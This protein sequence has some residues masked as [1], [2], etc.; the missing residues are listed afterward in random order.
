[1]FNV[2]MYWKNRTEIYFFISTSEINKLKADVV[3]DDF[4]T[5]D[6][7]GKVNLFDSP[8]LMAPNYISL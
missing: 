5:K 8:F 3:Q 4:H 6:E 1:M 7:S 2:S